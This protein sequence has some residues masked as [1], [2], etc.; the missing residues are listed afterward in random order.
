MEKGENA[1]NQNQKQI[2]LFELHFN[3]C[4]QNARFTIF[5]VHTLP[6]YHTMTTFINLE[7]EAF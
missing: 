6:N 3:C 5:V 4:I 2:L 7:K 1:G